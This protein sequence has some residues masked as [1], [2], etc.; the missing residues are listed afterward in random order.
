MKTKKGYFYDVVTN[1]R[2]EFMERET[3]MMNSGDYYHHNWVGPFKTFD[4]AKREGLKELRT[5]LNL[6]LGRYDEFDNLEEEK[7]K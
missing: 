7:K 2:I 3:G 4:K 6:A 1:M 5:E